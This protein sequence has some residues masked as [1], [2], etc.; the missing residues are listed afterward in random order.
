M[1]KIFEAIHNFLGK[2]FKKNERTYSKLDCFKAKYRLYMMLLY[3]VE[4]LIL[5]LYFILF[6]FVM[7]WFY[8]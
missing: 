3:F 1:K 6:F 5:V 8:G 7:R 2:V 4:H